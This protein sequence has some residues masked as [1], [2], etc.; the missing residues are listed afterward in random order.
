MKFAISGIIVAVAA[1]TS[2]AGVIQV[3]N[4]FGGTLTEGH[5]AGWEPPGVPFVKQYKIFGDGST[6][7]SNSGQDALHRTG[8]WFFNGF[9]G[10][11][12]GSWFQ[13]DTGG[14]GYTFN[15]AQPLLNFGGY[16]G[17]N[18]GTPGGKVEV[19]GAGGGFLGGFDL[20]CPQAEWAW[21]GWEA[22]GGDYITKVKI[23]PIQGQFNGFQMNDDL[24]ANVVPAPGAGAVLGLVIAGARRRR[25]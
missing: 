5:E 3:P 25:R 7:D 20:N 19:Y 2:L 9:I 24:V 16:F 10:A 18:C 23:I 22:T 12:S 14:G 6:V 4:P 11:R 8:G 1:G 17:T 13:G 15:F 21:N